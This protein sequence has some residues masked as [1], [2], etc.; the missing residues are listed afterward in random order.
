MF[1]RWDLEF[2]DDPRNVY[3]KVEN[4]H[5]MVR[6]GIAKDMPEVVNFFKEFSFS[7]EQIGSLMDAMNRTTSQEEAARQWM[8]NNSKLV[9]SWLGGTKQKRRRAGPLRS[10]VLTYFSSNQQQ[11]SMLMHQG[12]AGLSCGKK[13]RAARPRRRGNSRAKAG[14]PPLVPPD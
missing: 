10:G 7:D 12:G 1:A 13:G 9:D 8:K 5:T 11:L 6:P 14:R 2:L 4:I 3:G